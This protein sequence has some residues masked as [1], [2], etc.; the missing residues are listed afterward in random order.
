MD[1]N[2]VMNGDIKMNTIRRIIIIL[3]TGYGV[4]FSQSSQE[5]I[6]KRDFYTKTFSLG[7]NQY[8]TVFHDK[9]VHYLSETGEFVDIP[10]GSEHETYV[11]LARNQSQWYASSWGSYK[12]IVH[13]DSSISYEQSIFQ[14]AGQYDFWE[15]YEPGYRPLHVIWRGYSLF[16]GA[17]INPP[18]SPYPI[19]YDNVQISLTQF[20]IES[21]DPFAFGLIDVRASADF[22]VNVFPEAS[23]WTTLE[24]GGMLIN[25][26]DPLISDGTQTFD[27]NTDFY[28]LFVNS[29]MESDTDVGIILKKQEES[30]GY[31]VDYYLDYADVSIILNYTIDVPNPQVILRNIAENTSA[32]LGDQLSLTRAWTSDEII[33]Q[34]QD[35]TPIDVDLLAHYNALTYS[36]ELSGL[37]HHMWNNPDTYKLN[38][39]NFPIIEDYLNLGINARFNNQDNITITTSTP[40][41]LHL[42]DPWYLENPEAD[43]HLWVQPDEFRPLSEQGDGNGNVQ[44]FLN[45]NDQFQTGNPIYRLKAPQFY[46]T[47]DAIYEFSGWASSDTDPNDGI[48]DAVFGYYPGHESEPW[49]KEV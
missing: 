11:E 43:P 47:T 48:L 14:Y 18:A 42:H 20:W 23:D 34:S 35:E 37:R 5:L 16:P 40:V 2:Q 17:N 13:W 1:G 38:W 29:V 26:Y 49:W 45:Q 41:T 15:Y 12:K 10:V 22:S 28:N 31:Y 4:I 8:Q 39:Q 44:V 46:A 25:S 9:P 21:P 30:F 6:G 19:I 36:Y 7:N 32:N 24:S 27:S 3:I 33:V